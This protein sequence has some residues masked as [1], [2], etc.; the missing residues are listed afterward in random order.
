MQ[1]QYHFDGLDD[2]TKKI[3]SLKNDGL[4]H[5]NI[6]KILNIAKS[7]VGYN[8]NNKINHH[9]PIYDFQHQVT[10]GGLLGDSSLSRYHNTNGNRNCIID[11][12]CFGHSEKQLNYLETKR[13]LMMCNNK[14]R[15][16]KAE[17]GGY[18]K[19]LPF[20]SF[21]FCNKKYLTIIEKLCYK[22][23]K[24]FVSNVWLNQLKPLGIAI[25][26]QD[27]GHCSRV[28]YKNKDGI[29]TTKTIRLATDAFSDEELNNIITYFLKEWNIKFRKIK[30]RDN[31]CCL[32]CSSSNAEKFMK[33][34]RPYLIINK[35][36]NKDDFTIGAK[37]NKLIND[38][39]N[40]DY[41]L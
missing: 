22:N 4:S 2:L 26:Y 8:L 12:L 24:K 25:W 41:S 28:G 27:D 30:R 10:I 38:I 16:R 9:L 7:S 17:R 34:V 39:S 3:K 15:I 32:E 31:Q 35:T 36:W 18:G 23:N 14:I 1:I 5:K 13:K 19:A 21:R 11:S 29:Y 20:H 6:A 33:I 37:I 40:I